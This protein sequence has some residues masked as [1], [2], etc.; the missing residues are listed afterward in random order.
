MGIYIS[1]WINNTSIEPLPLTWVAIALY[2][3]SFSSG[4][5][6]PRTSAGKDAAGY[7]D[8]ILD[9]SLLLKHIEQLLGGT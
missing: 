4:P 3:A 1:T 7:G 5:A 9:G 8:E 2:A 6:K